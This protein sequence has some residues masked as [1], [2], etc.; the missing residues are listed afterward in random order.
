MF[1]FTADAADRIV[2]HPV[3]PTRHIHHKANSIDSGHT[4]ED[5]H[6][7]HDVIS[8]IGTAHAIL[9]TGP[10]NAKLELVKHIK[11]H[12]PQLAKLV[13]GVE[14]LDHPSDAALIAHARKY[15]VSAD[16]MSPQRE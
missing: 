15:F 6:F 9:I 4:P 11:R 13:A 7:F 16:R 10:A 8:A 12:D 2:V 14:T 5:Q 1:H 3:H